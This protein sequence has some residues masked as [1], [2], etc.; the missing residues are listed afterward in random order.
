[1]KTSGTFVAHSSCENCG[2]SDPVAVYEDEK[3]FNGYCFNCGTFYPSINENFRRKRRMYSMEDISFVESLPF[4]GWRDRRIDKNVSEFYG[5][6]SEMKEES[7]EKRYYPVYTNNELT[8]YKVRNC[9]EKDFR[10]IGQ[11]GK[12]SQLFGQHIFPGNGKFL[13]LT[14]GE[15]DAMAAYIMLSN[16]KY[17]TPCVSIAHGSNS[18]AEQIKANYKFVS[19]FETVVICFD[20][21][22]SGFEAAENVCRILKPGQA[23]IMK[24][25]LK[26]ANEYLISGLQKEFVDLFWKAE[27]YS[28]AGIVG[29]TDTWEALVQRSKFVKIPLPDFAE[30]LQKALNGGIAL[31]EIST[32]FASSGV[33]KST[34][35]YEFI[36]HWI[37]NSEYKVGIISLENDLGELTENLLSIHLNRKLANIPDEAKEQFFKTEEAK[38]AHKSLTTSSDGTDR[39]IILDHQGDMLEGDLQ[40]KMEYLVRVNGCKILILDPMTLALSGRGNDSTDQFMSWLV[41]FVK[42]EQIAHINV[43]HVRKAQGGQKAGSVG[44]T[45]HEEDGKGSSSIFQNSMNNIL[46]M[47]D[48]ENENVE[49]RNTIRVVLSKA[50]RTGNTGPAGFWK[51]NNNTSRLEKGRD[52][53]GQYEK[54]EEEFESFGFTNVKEEDF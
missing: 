18:A 19:S 21:D 39:F 37:F 6:H 4:R 50:R 26:D 47:R 11:G 8:G 20:N 14:E 13:V 40:S 35:T 24:M 46:I 38:E 30:E 48:K 10:I 43:V 3:G 25:R 5:V 34:I 42:R 9:I 52:P 41:S 36:Y 22:K 32:I 7:P 51:Y 27:R 44:G 1:M 12:H 16:G 31:S 49:I 17:K 23:K 45:I 28:P 54:D 33:G 2:G 29:S 15:E 53:N